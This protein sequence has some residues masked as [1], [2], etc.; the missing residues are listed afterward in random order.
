MPGENPFSMVSRNS[1]TTRTFATHYDPLT[2]RIGELKRER[3][4][5]EEEILQLRA[6]V[7]IWSAV[8]RQMMATA[9]PDALD[10]EM[11]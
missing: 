5:L 2:Q 3:A 8:R 11:Q 4:E 1:K 6:A 9:G 10:T 7:R